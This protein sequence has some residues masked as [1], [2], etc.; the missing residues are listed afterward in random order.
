MLQAKSL[1]TSMNLRKTND[2]HKDDFPD[3]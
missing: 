1:H 2:F 3:T